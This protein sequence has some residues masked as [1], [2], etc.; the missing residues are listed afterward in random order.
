MNLLDVR[1]P[2]RWNGLTA[3]RIVE[4]EGEALPHPVLFP[5][6]TADEI[7]RASPPGAEARLTDAGMIV[8]STQF[9]LL[10]EGVRVSIV[11]AGSGNGK[12]RPNEPYWDH[13]N[14]PYRETLGSLGVRPEDVDYVF[15]SHLHPDHV[16]LATTAAGE[17]WAPTFPRAQHVLSRREWEYWSGLPHRLPFIEDS[18][19]PL[20][21]A[22]C[23]RFAGDGDSIGGIRV[24]DTPGHT[25]GHLIFEAEAAGLWFL[26]DLLHHPAQAA[27]PDWPSA[28]WDVDRDGGTA[29]RRKFFRRFAD[30]GALLLGT[31]LGGPFRIEPVQDGAYRLRYEP[32]AEAETKLPCKESAAC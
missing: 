11:E 16:G 4:W 5:G 21:D 15:L 24:H 12:T 19:R 20:I 14:L 28:Q 10:R 32:A 13:Q 6:R 7:R 31:H 1:G 27:H 8:T 3:T 17:G 30:S 29:Q 26:G 25:P 23:V 2:Y 22:G 18:A 9:F